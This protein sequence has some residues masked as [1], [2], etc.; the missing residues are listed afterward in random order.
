MSIV[1]SLVLQRFVAINVHKEPHVNSNDGENDTGQCYCSELVNELYANE[2]NRS[3]YHQQDSAIYPEVV[4][5]N[6]GIFRK[7]AKYAESR[8]HVS[9]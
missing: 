6:I 5:H 3:H 2:D 1:I 4:V 7:I 8:G 9:L